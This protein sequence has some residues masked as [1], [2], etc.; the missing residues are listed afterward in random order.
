MIIRKFIGWT[1]LLGAFVLGYVGFPVNA[2]T[3]DD[4]LILTQSSTAPAQL[5][6]GGWPPAGWIVQQFDEL[7]EIKFPEFARQVEL[8]DD[9]IGRLGHRVAS[10]DYELRGRD[11]FLR[12]MLD[13]ACSVA[14]TSDGAGA[15]LID[16]INPNGANQS[17]IAIAP[18]TAPVPMVKPG[19]AQT[20]ARPSVVSPS[21]RL[22][23]AEAQQ[24]LMEQLLRAADAGMVDLRTDPSR[25][26]AEAEESTEPPTDS[27]VLLDQPATPQSPSASP[28]ATANSFQGDPASSK[29]K[30]DAEVYVANDE[31]PAP[32]PAPACFPE[33]AFAL[34]D[35][36]LGD[37][38]VRRASELHAILVGE[39]DTVNEEAAIKLAQL[40][41]SAGLGA[42]AIAVLDEFIPDHRWA[43]LYRE[44]AAVLNE[45][46]PALDASLRKEGC[47]GTQQLWRLAALSLT[48]SVTDTSDNATNFMAAL[49]AQPRHIREFLASRFGLAAV[50]SG[51]WEI[52]RRMEAMTNR[53][54]SSSYGPSGRALLL[55]A[56]LDAWHD[57]P[58]DAL[59]KLKRARNFPGAVA[60]DALLQLA[61]AALTNS[62]L[63][64]LETS[65][66]RAD[67]AMLA[68]DDHG[69][70]RGLEA[71]ELWVKLQ[72]H[73]LGRDAAMAVLN[74][75]VEDGLVPSG[76]RASLLA[77]IAQGTE[78][79]ESSSPLA[80]VYM[81]DP[82][83]FEGAMEKPGFR[84]AIVESMIALG[85]PSLAENV[86]TPQDQEDHSLG[87]DLARAHLAANEP[88]RAI[89]GLRKLPESPDRNQVM[90]R[91]LL[92][93]GKTAEA[94]S[95][96]ADPSN[97]EQEV[98]DQIS[99]M[100]GQIEAALRSEEID[101]ALNLGAQ[102]LALVQDGDLAESLAL[103]A[104]DAGHTQ[105]PPS[106]TAALSNDQLAV[107]KMLFD[108]GPEL[109]NIVD[110]EQMN[111]FIDQLSSEISTI[112]EVLNDG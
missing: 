5:R 24:H 45:E 55:S 59:V 71:F 84:R 100:D 88:Q 81:D 74:Q 12:L 32:R 3:A 85:L 53:S 4:R 34:Q 9:L 77:E 86:M 108:R 97:A 72:D 91:A 33:E 66:L 93:D 67:L 58:R 52:A 13:C 68:R 8:P 65:Y 39:F 99:L 110:I 87:L 109:E 76:R 15:V 29:K 22:N 57:R 17:E 82:E 23:V 105:L 42:E 104:L 44:V 73:E 20:E 83:R 25:P 26:T 90:T 112:E 19:T 10:L 54:V 6:L 102:R 47:N 27:Q 50:T 2:E 40:N 92:A 111:G 56:R 36:E 95:Y 60:E 103:A 63:A 41:L 75:G 94:Q 49:E 101:V 7:V 96:L 70:K 80:L 37:P 1:I 51:N 21:G 69:G 61:K 30:A 16:L 79:S 38:Y 43:E 35:P 107:L 106:L 14:V 48:D 46:P 11:L 31:V 28:A 98:D 89:A 62:D 78:F 18:K 64:T